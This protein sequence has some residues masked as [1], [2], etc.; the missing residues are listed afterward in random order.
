MYKVLGGEPVDL[1]LVDLP[2]HRDEPPVGFNVRE[3]ERKTDPKD[4]VHLLSDSQCLYRRGAQL[5]GR[6][7]GAVCEFSF[8]LFGFYLCC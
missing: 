3:R 2:V 7:Y 4:M 1:I 5:G 8:M 6:G